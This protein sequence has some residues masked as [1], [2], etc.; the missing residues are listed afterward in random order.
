MRIMDAY[1]FTRLEPKG[2]S[3]QAGHGLRRLPRWQLWAYHAAT[4]S[5]GLR[6]Y[7]FLYRYRAVLYYHSMYVNYW[8]ETTYVPGLGHSE[9]CASRM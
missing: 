7:L 3:G 6:V 1:L 2:P 8:H 9:T 4:R 5:E